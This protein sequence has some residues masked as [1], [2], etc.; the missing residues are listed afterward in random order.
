M[1]HGSAH[2]SHTAAGLT[3]QV[4]VM[5]PGMRSMSPMVQYEWRRHGQPGGPWEQWSAEWALAAVSA[6]RDAAVA[7]LRTKRQQQGSVV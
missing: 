6:R 1:S 2:R 7:F 3:V 5:A 4:K